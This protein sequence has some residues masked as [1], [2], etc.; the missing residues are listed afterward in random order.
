MW[1]RTLWFASVFSDSGWNLPE[2]YFGQIHGGFIRILRSCRDRQSTFQTRP[3]VWSLFKVKGG[4]QWPARP[5]S[6]VQVKALSELPP[7]PVIR[8]Q[9]LGVL[10]A[11]AGK[12]VRQQCRTSP[13]A[14][15]VFRAYSEKAQEAAV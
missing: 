6:P 7:L 3:K 13:L 4:L 12:L 11:P 10:Q 5:L 9:L 15:F 14:G 1:S 2:G 8:A